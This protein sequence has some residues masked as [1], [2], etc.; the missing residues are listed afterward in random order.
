MDLHLKGKR[1]I[2]LGGTRGIGRAIAE[3]LAAEGADVGFCARNADQVAQAEAALTAKGV[4]A[5]GGS[6]DIADG[7]ALGAWVTATA[8]ALG[9]LDVL[10]SNASGIAMGNAP[11]AWAANLNIDCLGAIAAFEAA[12]PFLKEAA[13]A[14][15]DAAAVFIA[16][17]SAA[18]TQ[19]AQAYGALKAALIH[20]A[21]GYAKECAKDRIRVNAVS[22]GTILFE[23]GVWD[24]VQKNMPDMFKATLAR[25]PLG[26]MGTP[27]EIAAMTVFLASPLSRF[28]TGANVV[29]DGG[30]TGRVNF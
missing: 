12:R 24:M 8:E 18:E 13:S 22:P 6:V 1:A 15:G 20:L 29:V 17:V 27:E 16:S 10:V 30:I 23:G 11:A 25:N 28:T 2:V 9:G 7:A 14:R 19:N 5:I 21:K 26:R 4:R 3:L